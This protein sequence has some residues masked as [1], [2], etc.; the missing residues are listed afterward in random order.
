MPKL[1]LASELGQS[2]NILPDQLGIKLEGKNVAFVDNAADPYKPNVPWVEADLQAFE[3]KGS[4]VEK[5]DLQALDN[6]QII[7]RISQ[8]DILHINGGSTLYLLKLLQDKNLVQPLRQLILQDKVIY[9][10]SSAGSMIAGPN[11]ECCQVFDELGISKEIANFNSLNLVNFVVL[12]HM[13]NQ[14]DHDEALKV[15]QN[16]IRPNYSYITLS[17]NQAIWVSGGKFEILNG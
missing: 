9:T 15:I 11:L 1:L 13:Q 5:I 3:S 4:I 7:E 14:P 10:G 8:S 17:D 2:I 16:Y 6:N 12:P